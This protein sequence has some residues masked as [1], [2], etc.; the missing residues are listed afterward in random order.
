MNIR[1]IS[2]ITIILTFLLV[3]LGGYVHNTESSLACPDWPLCYGQ[4]FPNM[5][6]GI[7]IEHSHRLLA[8]LVGLMTIFIL[9]LHFKKKNENPF[10]FKVSLSA[11]ALVIFQ[12]VL[13]GLTVI[14]KL[15]TLVSTAHLATSMLFFGILIFIHHRSHQVLFVKIEESN[16][17]GNVKTLIFWSILAVYSQ[18]ILGA[19]MRHLGLGPAC[20]LGLE[21]SFLCFDTGLWKLTLFPISTISQIH[22][23]HRIY[24]IFVG[25]I[26]IYTSFKFYKLYRGQ[27]QFKQMPL[28]PI[29]LVLIQIALGVILISNNIGQIS[30]TLHLG[31]AAL[32]IGYLWKS[33]LL[34]CDLESFSFQKKINSSLADLI[35]LGKPKLSA[36]VIS[37][38][39]LGLLMAPGKISFFTAMISMISTAGVVGG[40]CSLN[41]YIE[42][43]IDALMERTKNRPL[44]SGR[45]RESL[46]LWWGV[47][48]VSFFTLLLFWFVNPLTGILAIIATLIYIFMY[49]PLK[50][51]TTFAL[52]AGAIPGAIPPLMGWTSVT[53]SLDAMALTMFGI[54]FIWQ[55]PHF[56]A[57]A[58]FHL[59][60]YETAGFKVLPSAIGKEKTILMIIG[61]TLVLSILTFLPYK[62]GL[63]KE[64]YRNLSLLLGG[65]FLGYSLLGWLWL[66]D[67]K[68]LL[69]WSRRYFYASLIYLPCVFG[70]MVFLK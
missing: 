47:I 68:K 25:A 6:G 4:V 1:L 62:L 7:L 67:Q 66:N 33:Y 54:L 5:E 48:N 64:L 15:P 56:L 20:G 46:A 63:D 59:K 24:A 28:L 32:L 52:Y 51:K 61:T 70:L 69:T 10:L 40:A 41:S 57:I 38:S 55:I 14:F 19:F 34:V 35:D 8:S 26:V 31:V 37:T 2:F 49:T 23:A 27:K 9:I 58:I 43:D 42:R 65:A 16:W 60:D 50:T 18:M 22:M 53:N 3:N 11:L 29:F 45:I 21:N 39:F 36:L 13:G 12:G 17:D 30:T 44:P